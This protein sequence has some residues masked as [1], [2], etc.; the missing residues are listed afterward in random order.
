MDRQHS[1]VVKD[2]LELQEPYVLPV[3]VYSPIQS[4]TLPIVYPLRPLSAT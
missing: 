4:L 3:T 2:W 1:P